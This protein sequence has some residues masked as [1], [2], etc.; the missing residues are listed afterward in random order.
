MEPPRNPPSARWAPDRAGDL[1]ES[2]GLILSS[3]GSLLSLALPAQQRLQRVLFV[4]LWH[5]LHARPARRRHPELGEEQPHLV[6]RLK[7]DGLPIGPSRAR[8]PS[9]DSGRP[10]DGSRA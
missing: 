3:R 5:D 2:A 8:S 6:Q 1:A 4:P 7:V 10:K 9:V